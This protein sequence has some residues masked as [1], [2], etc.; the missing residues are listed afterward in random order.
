M[1]PRRGPQARKHRSQDSLHHPQRR[2]PHR[3]LHDSSE[4]AGSVRGLS[5]N[6]HRQSADERDEF[7]SDLCKAASEALTP[8]IGACCESD[9]PA[10]SLC[11]FLLM[12]VS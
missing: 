10:D 2:K 11:H 1:G 7:L 3:C 9:F 6:S 12:S 4:E 8:L 5:Q